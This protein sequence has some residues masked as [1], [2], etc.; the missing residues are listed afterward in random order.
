M[1]I[2][3]AFKFKHEFWRYLVGSVIVFIA[4]LVG[5]LPLTGVLLYKAVKNGL[6]LEG[7]DES[8]M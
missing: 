8:S 1:F 6:G 2:K 5:Q 4:A 7:L 3:Q